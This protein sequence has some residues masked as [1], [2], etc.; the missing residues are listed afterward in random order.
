M[1]SRSRIRI[2]ARLSL[3]PSELLFTFIRAGGPGGQNVN[4]V[5]TAVQL[6]FDAADTPSLPAAV[7]R[8][9][10]RLAGQR[11]TAAGEIIITA[12]RFR[13]QEANRRDAVGRLVDLIRK[14]AVAPKVRVA[15]KPSRS[16][17][18]RRLAG[19]KHR[20]DIKQKRRGGGWE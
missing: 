4:K 16:A 6:R 15:T 3:D 2:N 8:R 11:A 5:A 19:K 20:G 9:L 7:R 18:E 12:Q 13:T 10:S 14:A 1:E 17:K